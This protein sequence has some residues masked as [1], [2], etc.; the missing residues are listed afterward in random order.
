VCNLIK[1]H[2]ERDKGD[3]VEVVDV[4]YWVKGCSSL[5]RLRFAVLLGIGKKKKSSGGFCLIDIKEAVPGR[6]SGAG[7]VELPERNQMEPNPSSAPI[8]NCTS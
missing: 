2:K 5:G 4:A 8:S 3:E 1:S 7:L 6:H